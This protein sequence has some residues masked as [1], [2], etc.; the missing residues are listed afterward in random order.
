MQTSVGFHAPFMRAIAYCYYYFTK[1]E[2]TPKRKY[3]FS[4]R[5]IIIHLDMRDT[6]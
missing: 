3:I 6:L 5:T 1:P 4:E 2:L